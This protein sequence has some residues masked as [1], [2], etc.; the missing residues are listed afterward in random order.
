VIMEQQQQQQQQQQPY[1]ASTSDLTT[2]VH[3]IDIDDDESTTMLLPIMGRPFATS[4]KFW[5]QRLPGSLLIGATSGFSV[6]AFLW[7][8]QKCLSLL[9]LVS[10]LEKEEDSNDHL[11]SLFHMHGA[12]PWL[13][14]LGITSMGGLVSG[15][16]FLLP[17]TPP[18]LGACKTFLHNA[19]DLQANPWESLFVI[20]SSFV[21]LA[22]GGPLGRCCVVCS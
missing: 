16:C 9:R 14:L 21:V 19:V 2:D 22:T 7:T 5:Y 15:V 12:P 13:L 20:F 3:D 4:A 11:L 6:A 18:R 8:T 17:K 10:P 1:Q